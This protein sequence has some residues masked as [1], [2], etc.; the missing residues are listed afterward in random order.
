MDRANKT[1]T[2]HT[3]ILTIDLVGAAG[4]TGAMSIPQGRQTISTES[5]TSLPKEKTAA[6][7]PGMAIWR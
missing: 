4:D 2:H 7:T 3:P 5:S 6:R 1:T